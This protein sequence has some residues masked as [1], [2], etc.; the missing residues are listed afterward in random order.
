MWVACQGE[1]SFIPLGMLFR[2][3]DIGSPKTRVAIPAHLDAAIEQSRATRLWVLLWTG[4]FIGFAGS[5]LCVLAPPELRTGPAIASQALFAVGMCLVLTDAFF[6][7]VTAIP[8]TGESPHEQPNLALTVLKYF[9]FFP[10]V[11]ALPVRL[12]P[13][14][15]AR[16]N[17]FLIAGLIFGAAHL[18]LQ[19]SHRTILREYSSQLALEDDEEDFPMKLGLRY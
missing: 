4:L 9:T 13:W 7:H 5:A 1:R 2:Q 15:E 8:F 6:L 14:I 11:A 16:P 18:L 19:R 17:H 3:N 12:E 10:V